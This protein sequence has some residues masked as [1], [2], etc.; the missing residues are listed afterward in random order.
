V[1]HCP[2]FGRDRLTRDSAFVSGTSSISLSRSS[3]AEVCADLPV[4]GGGVG[5]SSRGSG[6]R[7]CSYSC[8][9]FAPKSVPLPSLLPA[10][11]GLKER[12][13]VLVDLQALPHVGFRAAAGFGHGHALEGR[14]HRRADV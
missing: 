3:T 10:G 13:R 5:S 9:T 14:L 8:L 11:E 2:S 12:A 7:T 4:G 1:Y 6:R